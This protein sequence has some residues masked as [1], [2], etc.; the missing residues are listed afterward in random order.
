MEPCHDFEV[1]SI[2]EEAES[3]EEWKLEYDGWFGC[4][5][6]SLYE[7]V[8]FC[9]FI[10]EFNKSDHNSVVNATRVLTPDLPLTKS[11]GNML[12]DP[13]QLTGLFRHC[14]CNS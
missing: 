11:V 8:T 9:S 3:L 5:G 2:T 10:S 12:I 6:S 7:S 13:G 1:D 4:P 14:H